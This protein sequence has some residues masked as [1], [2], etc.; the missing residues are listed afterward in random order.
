MKQAGW[1]EVRA[2]RLGIGVLLDA[3]VLWSLLTARDEAHARV[4]RRL[5][6]LAE[7]GTPLAVT[8]I[9]LAQIAVRVHAEFGAGKASTVITMLRETLNI[10]APV[11]EDLGRAEAILG[12]GVELLTLEQSVAG[13]VAQRLECSVYGTS[14]AYHLFHVAIIVD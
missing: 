2:S 6:A 9:T 7:Q 5:L 13:A 4:A 11:E 1:P 3:A 10:V 12:Q 14:P 8:Y